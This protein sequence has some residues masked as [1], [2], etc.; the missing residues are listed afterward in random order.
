[1]AF[2]MRETDEMVND[3]TGVIVIGV[4][5]KVG[6]RLGCQFTTLAPK[7]IPK[8]ESRFFS[9]DRRH[10]WGRVH[11]RRSVKEN[12]RSQVIGL[13]LGA[14]DTGALQN[15]HQRDMQKF[16]YAVEDIREAV[17]LYLRTHTKLA[18]PVVEIV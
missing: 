11:G 8:P 16:A 12:Y 18:N 5:G 9:C 13:S 7:P 4:Y 2:H 10:D 6:K 14:S 1:M 3:D 17:L 15:Y